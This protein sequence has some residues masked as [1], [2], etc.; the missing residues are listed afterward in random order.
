MTLGVWR[1]V[2]R[3][4]SEFDVPVA[5]REA[6]ALLL[7]VERVVPC[8]PGAELTEVVDERNFVGQ[9]KVR[10]GAISLSFRGEVE[11]EEVDTEAYRVVMRARGREARGKGA[12]EATVT[13][14]LE[15]AGLGTRVS[16]LADL[17]LSGPVAH[18]GHGMIQDVSAR[19]TEQFADNLSA[20][21]D[22]AGEAEK[23]SSG[24]QRPP[25]LLVLGLGAFWRALGRLFRKLPSR[26]ARRNPS[27]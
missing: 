7:D 5:R 1:G 9:V 4:A 22:G 17:K 10:L 13:S 25:D 16:V 21:L 2:M 20:Q 12:A 6:L 3:F 19:L 8:F 24:A 18:F 27:D 15:E 11:L 26:R 23:P 14:L